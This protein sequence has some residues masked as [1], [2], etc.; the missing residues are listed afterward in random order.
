MLELAPKFDNDSGELKATRKRLQQLQARQYDLPS[1]LPARG[2]QSTFS[3]YDDDDW[4]L[5]AVREFFSNNPAT[6]TA[7][8]V[9]N[10]AH[11]R[12][13]S[14]AIPSNERPNAPGEEQED[15]EASEDLQAGTEGLYKSTRA[16]KPRRN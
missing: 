16:H 12:Q 13:I 14:L 5:D 7:A 15:P 1:L 10:T 2:T 11:K 3:H 9:A 4:D 8:T 6:T